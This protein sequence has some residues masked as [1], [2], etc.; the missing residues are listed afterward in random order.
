MKE[1]Q[2]QTKDGHT[3]QHT[4]ARQTWK[5]RAAVGGRRLKHCRV[6]CIYKRDIR[7]VVWAGQAIVE[8]GLG[9]SVPRRPLSTAL[10]SL[11]DGAIPFPLRSRTP[12]SQSLASTQ[13]GAPASR[14]PFR[15][16]RTRISGKTQAPRIQTRNSATSTRPTR[17]LF[18][19]LA[20]SVLRCLRTYP[21]ILP[22]LCLAALAGLLQLI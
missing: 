10:V 18:A 14:P 16:T 6:S 17:L 19:F 1:N 11:G 15:Q 8:G 7:G 21:C 5:Q 3:T 2:G 13:P 12:Q 22:S 4:V 9:P 20:C